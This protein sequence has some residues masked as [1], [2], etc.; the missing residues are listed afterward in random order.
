[1]IKLMALLN[2]YIYIYI[3]T[4]SLNSL[5]NLILKSKKVKIGLKKKDSVFQPLKMRF[6]FYL[7]GWDLF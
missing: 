3:Y 7:S 1:M 5:E 2:K 4:Y 6:F